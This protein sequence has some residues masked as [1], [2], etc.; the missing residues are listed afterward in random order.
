[1][2]TIYLVKKNPAVQGHQD[3]WITMNSYEFAMFM[4]TEEGK[5]RRPFFGELDAVDENDY[6]IVMEFDQQGATDLKKEN[7]RKRYLKKVEAESGYKTFSLNE[8]RD[9]CYSR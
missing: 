1:M 6:K 2:K 4:K 3:N 5:R 7:N 9:N 8:L